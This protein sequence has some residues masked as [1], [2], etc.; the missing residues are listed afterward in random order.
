MEKPN[1]PPS[2]EDK[3]FEI[4]FE[5]G[6]HI[7][8][9]IVSYFPLTDLERQEILALM[10]DESFDAFRSIFSDVISEDEWNRT[11]E[12]IKKKFQSDLFD[13]DDMS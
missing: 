13:I 7:L 5:A 9:K 10:N 4:Q 3:I 12:Q 6:N 11:K 2:L 8:S 1:F